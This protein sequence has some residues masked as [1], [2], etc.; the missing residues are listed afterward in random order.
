MKEHKTGKKRLHRVRLPLL[1]LIALVIGL[2]LYA[3]N[4][5]VLAGNALPMPFGFGVAVVLSGSMEPELSVDDV[6]IVRPADAYAVGDNV[7]Y[8]DGGTLV[9]HKIIAIDGETVTTQGTA[10]NTPDDPI[11]QRYI[12]GRVTG[13][14]P[15]VGGL[16]HLIRS[17]IVSLAI[18]ALAVYL[19]ICAGRAEQREQQDK[20]G[21]IRA[22]IERLKRERDSSQ[23]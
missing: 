8:Q 14:I 11:H 12:K 15:A 19:L 9:V 16:I 23:Q 20:L 17:P 10:N 18:L 7:V 2:N 5:T 13:V 1:I 4:A 6:I 22:E 3:W 21:E